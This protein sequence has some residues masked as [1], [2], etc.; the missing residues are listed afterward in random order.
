MALSFRSM[1]KAAVLTVVA[2]DK[3]DFLAQKALDHAHEVGRWCVEVETEKY[4]SVVFG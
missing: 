1:L 4:S 2:A 3:A